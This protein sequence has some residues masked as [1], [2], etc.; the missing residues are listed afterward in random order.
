[1]YRQPLAF[2]T[3]AKIEI[4]VRSGR[5]CRVRFPGDETRF[6]IERSELTGR[7]MHG[8]ARVQ[9]IATAYY[10][11]NPGYKGRDRFMFRVCG[12]HDGKSACSNI[13]VRVFVR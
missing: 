8:G 3:D 12:R 9:D 5:D 1:M 4:I 2:G 6:E 10:R 11:S 13:V 7:P